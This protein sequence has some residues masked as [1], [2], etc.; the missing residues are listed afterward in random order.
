VQLNAAHHEC[1]LGYTSEQQCWWSQMAADR[2]QQFWSRIPT[3]AIGKVGIVTAPYYRGFGRESL[4]HMPLSVKL[5]TSIIGPA[6]YLLVPH[7][8]PHLE[9]Y[10]L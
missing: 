8:A 6:H 3:Y 7:K 10:Q 2:R 9:T 4:A 5:T 1:K